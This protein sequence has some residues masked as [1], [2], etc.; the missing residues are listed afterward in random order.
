[1]VF[2]G[3]IFIAIWDLFFISIYL[4]PDVS[5]DSRFTMVFVGLLFLLCTLLSSVSILIGRPEFSMVRNKE[6]Q[7][8]LVT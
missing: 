2:L 8:E 4:S 5:P 7:P 6:S 3:Q 1:M